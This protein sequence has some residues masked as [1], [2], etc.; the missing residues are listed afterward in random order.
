MGLTTNTKTEQWNRTECRHGPSHPREFYRVP[1]P[2]SGERLPFQE[3]V[4]TTGRPGQHRPGPRLSLCSEVAGNDLRPR[5]EGQSYAGLEGVGVN[6]RERVW[7]IV[8]Q[9]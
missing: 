8:S 1:R 9:V 7:G 4:E 3:H 2:F 6:T 5:R